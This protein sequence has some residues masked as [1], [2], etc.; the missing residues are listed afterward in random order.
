MNK[1]LTLALLTAL[2]GLGHAAPGDDSWENRPTAARNDRTD[3]WWC[4]TWRMGDHVET[5]Y[6]YQFTGRL[7]ASTDSAANVR[8]WQFVNK[9]IDREMS[10]EISGNSDATTDVLMG[11]GPNGEPLP[12]GVDVQLRRTYGSPMSYRGLAVVGPTN[13][14]EME[15]M[16]RT[17]IVAFVD[18]VDDP[19]VQER[20]EALVQMATPGVAL[21]VGENLQGLAELADL[22]WVSEA[23]Q[24]I[25]LEVNSAAKLAGEAFDTA[26]DWLR[27][28]RAK[29]LEKLAGGELDSNGIEAKS[30]G[31]FYLNFHSK[32]VDKLSNM[33]A[34]FNELF[35]YSCF[36]ICGRAGEPL[37]AKKVAKDG[38]ARDLLANCDDFAALPQ[39]MRKLP[40]T[41]DDNKARNIIARESLDV[42]AKLFGLRERK[43]GDFWVVDASL[44]DGF[45]HQDLTGGFRGSVI[46]N[47]VGDEKL[48]LTMFDQAV[49]A[50]T[51]NVRHLKMVREHRNKFTSFKYEEP[52]SF[53]VEYDPRNSADKNE[54]SLDLFVDTASGHIV[55][56]RARFATSRIK[57]LPKLG[58]SDG[59][60]SAEGQ[61]NFKIDAETNPTSLF[62]KKRAK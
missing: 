32:D 26:M 29:S 36:Y 50:R 60:T 54:A 46:M 9:Y 43:P 23:L 31:W 48:S 14:L 39:A 15:K 11:V 51:F 62:D 25:G 61:V 34:S 55:K 37:F 41:A 6:A 18:Q 27:A 3:R 42:N 8:W 2:T 24:G 57:A 30:K 16:L 44:L 4:D 17:A 22:A 20:I 45:L 49:N 28:T 1:A 12:P 53:T 58:L 59:F 52:G 40:L 5:K 56:V 47:Y 19:K 7:T 33:A 13:G 21:A 38:P 10:A 35:S